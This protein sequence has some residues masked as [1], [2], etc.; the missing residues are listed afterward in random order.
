[1]QMLE[2]KIPP[3][4]LFVAVGAAMWGVGRVAQPIHLAEAV[5]LP[6]TGGFLLVALALAGPA[7]L[8]FRRTGT[9]IDPIRPENASTMVTSGIYR[10]TRNPMYVG[11]TAL[12]LG[13]AV[14]LSVPWALAGPVFFA[15]YLNRLQIIPEERAMAGKFGRSYELY[16]QHVRRWL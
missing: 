8:E 11:L 12:L 13:W 15:V 4:L 14:W 5:R 1:M 16:R 9:T 10:I 6:L 7:F 3:P 2:T